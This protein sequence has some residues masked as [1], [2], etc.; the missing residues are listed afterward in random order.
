M[1]KFVKYKISKVTAKKTLIKE[2]TDFM[3]ICAL[4]D[5]ER[6]NV[7][8]FT[9][10]GIWQAENPTLIELDNGWGLKF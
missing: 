10:I 5:S 2:G 8:G 3:C 4:V 6:L 1:V 9:E 7:C